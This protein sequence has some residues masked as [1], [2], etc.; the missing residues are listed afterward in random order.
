[1]YIFVYIISRRANIMIKNRIENII[2]KDL[3]IRF[4]TYIVDDNENEEKAKV[5]ELKR[6]YC[7][8]NPEM[9]KKIANFLDEPE[10]SIS[11]VY[12]INE[13]RDIDSSLLR[14]EIVKYGGDF[15]FDLNIL[16]HGKKIGYISLTRVFVDNPC[17][18]IGFIDC[19]SPQ[20]L[21][22]AS[23][24]CDVDYKKVNDTYVAIYDC[25]VLD[26]E[27][28]GVGIEKEVISMLDSFLIENEF[29]VSKTYIKAISISEEDY[30]RDIKSEKMLRIL[31]DNEYILA[32]SKTNIMY[33]EFWDFDEYC[34]SL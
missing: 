3:S 4:D 31:R 25:F 6:N 22:I 17:E 19:E 27:Y 32:D 10:E 1:M 8:M 33:S 21:D 7:K 18:V 28:Q 12:A 9:S 15:C 14:E 5:F 34:E 16:L 26:K 11:K 24:I 23:Y 2:N 13:E 20:S 30:S 29:E